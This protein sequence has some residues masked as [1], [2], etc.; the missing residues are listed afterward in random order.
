MLRRQADPEVIMGRSVRFLC[1]VSALFVAVPAH[2]DHALDSFARDVSRTAGVRAVKPLQRSYAQYAQYGQWGHIGALF[3]ADG[4]FVFDG[5]VGPA[6]SAKGPAAIA[7][8]LRTR[9]GGGKEGTG[10]GGLSTM[11]IENPLVNLSADGATAKARWDVLIF[12]GHKGQARIEGGI[13]ENDYVLDHG[14]WKIAVAHYYPHYDGA[15][16]TGWT[17][18]GGGDLPIVPHHFAV[19]TAGIPL[20]PA[21][22][23]APATRR[24]LASLPAA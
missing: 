13:F 3:A 6:Q 1:A 11:F 22:G 2:A 24:T 4:T 7:A 12:H 20:P 23:A 15:Y 8:F 14:V 16:E 5:Q 10:A 18:W 17:N 9:Y 19:R 21:P